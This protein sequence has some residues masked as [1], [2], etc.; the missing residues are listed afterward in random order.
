[1]SFE[2]S[3][4][5]A[6]PD[7][8]RVFDIR[9]TSGLAVAPLPSARTSFPLPIARAPEPHIGPLQ[10]VAKKTKTSTRCLIAVFHATPQIET[11]AQ[12]H[13]SYGSSAPSGYSAS[14]SGWDSYGGGHDA[15]GSY[16][17]NVAQTLAYSGQKPA[18]R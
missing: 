13:G 3:H 18:T 16:S 2:V 10:T 8:S 15:H 4:P 9:V 14:S 12:P 7:V 5:S 6:R 11:H 1:M 17:N